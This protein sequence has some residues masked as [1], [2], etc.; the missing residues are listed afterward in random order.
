LTHYVIVRAD[1]PTGFLAA[2]VVHAAGE[3]S[4]GNL[5]S[6]TNAVVLSVPD[7]AALLGIERRLQKEG[8]RHVAIREP[9]AP[10]LGALTAIG[11]VPLADKRR[12]KPILSSLPLLGKERKETPMRSCP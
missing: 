7:E 11:L 3:S 8:V 2:Q 4:P 6:G 1:L 10:Y 5:D 12:V 9:D